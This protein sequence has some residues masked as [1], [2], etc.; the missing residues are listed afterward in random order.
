MNDGSDRN[1]GLVSW[2][3]GVAHNNFRLTRIEEHLGRSINQ[4][5]DYEQLDAML[6]E[7]RTYYPNSYRIFMN[8]QATE[9]QLIRASRE[10]WG[11]GHEGSR[12]QVAQET[13]AQ[14]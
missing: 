7:M 3:D 13:L 11:Y 14:L 10:Y 2:M 9:R 6:W 1:G 4:A 12:Y 5:N 8:P